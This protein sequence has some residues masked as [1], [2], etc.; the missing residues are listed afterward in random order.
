MGGGFC[1]G[2]ALTWACSIS[3]VVEGPRR[4]DSGANVPTWEG[5]SG[6]RYYLTVN[7]ENLGSQCLVMDADADAGEW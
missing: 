1:P 4:E 6:R 5:P 2:V 7:A 3:F